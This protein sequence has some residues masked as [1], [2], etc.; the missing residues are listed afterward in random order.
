MAGE[1]WLGHDK[2]S[3]I[4][5]SETQHSLLSGHGVSDFG[6][7]SRFVILYERFILSREEDSYKLRY[8][9]S[10]GSENRLNIRTNFVTAD[11]DGDANCGSTVGS[12]WHKTDSSCVNS[13]LF[14]IPTQGGLQGAQWFGKDTS[15][16]A[17]WKWMVKSLQ[18]EFR[19]RF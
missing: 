14:G 11:H 18:G 6:I 10:F 9:T 16:V 19:F 15:K 12:Y 13:N 8:T 3:Y 4:T 7:I 1:F 5:S 2:I 17:N